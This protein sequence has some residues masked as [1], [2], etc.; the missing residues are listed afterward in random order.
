MSG[1][2]YIMSNPSFQ[3]GLIKIGMSDRDPTQFRKAEL[4]TTGVPDKFYV[5][6]YAFISDHYAFVRHIHRKLGSSRPNKNREFFKYPIPNAIDLIRQLAGG[7]IEYEKVY[8]KSPEEIEK[9][10]LERE[11]VERN[12]ESQR[13]QKESER[14]KKEEQK[15]QKQLVDDKSKEILSKID[16]VKWDLLDIPFPDWQGWLMFIFQLILLPIIGLSLDKIIGAIFI[17]LG[18]WWF[19]SWQKNREQKMELLMPIAKDEVA[20]LYWQLVKDKNW[21][22]NYKSHLSQTVINFKSRINNVEVSKVETNDSCIDITRSDEGKA[23]SRAVE[24]RHARE[25][26]EQVKSQGTVDKKLK[27]L[28]NNNKE[29][30]RVKN[31]FPSW[32]LMENTVLKEFLSVYCDYHEHD[33]ESLIESKFVCRDKDDESCL[34]LMSSKLKEYLVKRGLYEFEI[35][36]FIINGSMTTWKIMADKMKH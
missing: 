15:R 34:L 20:K 3:H 6:Y 4:E 24:L 12:A 16:R 2:I 11:R 27:A 36:D 21:K 23:I 17:P 25:A 5:E 18:I 28:K 14:Q 29:K 8:Y 31:P 30:I 35:E 33:I 10:R 1:F 13:K 32:A 7:S 26:K 22:V 19:L 9:I